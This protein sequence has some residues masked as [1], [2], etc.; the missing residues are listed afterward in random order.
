MKVCH[1]SDAHKQEDTRIFHKECTSLVKAGFSVYEIIPGKS[2]VKNGVNIIGVTSA[3]QSLRKRV[4]ATSKN[5]FRA[6]LALDADVYH[7]HDPELMPIL[8]KLKKRGKKVIFDSHENNIGLISE[9][10]YIPKCIR[11]LV[12][13]VF[14]AYQKSACLKFDAVITATPN[15]TE[16]FKTIGCSRVID[17]CNFPLLKHDVDTPDYCSRRISF[18]GGIT[19]QWNHEHIINSISRIDDVEYCLC[20][21]GSPDYLSYLRS[22]D[23]WD[24]VDYLGNLPFERVSEVLRSTAIGLSLLTPGANTD[25]NNG[26]LANTKIFEEMQA[27]LPVVCTDFTRWKDF[28][29]AYD[30]GICVNPNSEEQIQSAIESLVSNPEK[31]KTM[32]MNGK[33]AVEERFNWSIEEKKLI[34]LYKQIEGELSE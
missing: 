26:N 7:A 15:M 13:N 19:E 9:K 5:V 1:L 2:Y 14:A 20:G 3:G 22:L 32:G 8:L 18:A 23:G 12:Q 4:F 33:R 6:A 11:K 21:K 16:Y 34:S 25:W 27:G 10:K 24:K 28:V 30:C 17:L 29:E 31:A